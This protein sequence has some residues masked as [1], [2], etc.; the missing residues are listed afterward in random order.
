[1]SSKITDLTEITTPTADDIIAVVDDPTGSPVTSFA[2][3]VNLSNACS[4]RVL[5]VDTGIV[6]TGAIPKIDFDLT[7][8]SEYATL[9]IDFQFSADTDSTNLY[10]QGYADSGSGTAT[11]SGKMKFAGFVWTALGVF[12][13][14]DV[15]AGANTWVISSDMAGSIAHAAGQIWLMNWQTQGPTHLFAN[16]CVRRAGEA[17][18]IDRSVCM[19]DTG[20]D[21][22]SIR[23][24]GG[25]SGLFDSGKAILWG[26]R[27]NN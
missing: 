17:Q 25:G 11:A 10:M 14:T 27:G 3:L 26:L 23:L 2:S 12:S 19:M 4:D 6:D 5:L 18:S 15:N 24:A 9:V 22:H 20:R 21:L 8:Y 1:M 7:A 13:T 16:C